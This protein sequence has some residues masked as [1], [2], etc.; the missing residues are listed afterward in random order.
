M[1]MEVRRWDFIERAHGHGASTSSFSTVRI[2]L[3]SHKA[4]AF[5]WF[6][7]NKCKINKCGKYRN[8][9]K[10]KREINVNSKA[11]ENIYKI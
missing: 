6:F 2:D 4:T 9:V 3:G 10:L 1:E 7:L 11:K 8:R 5:I